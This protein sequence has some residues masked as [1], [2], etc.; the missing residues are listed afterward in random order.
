MSGFKNVISNDSEILI[1]YVLCK[2]L[3]RRK[4]FRMSSQ[5][6]ALHYCLSAVKP[7]EASVNG[8]EI[9][10]TVAES[11]CQDSGNPA[12]YTVSILLHNRS[13]SWFPTCYVDTPRGRKNTVSWSWPII[14]GLLQ[15]LEKCPL[16][17]VS[18][19]MPSHFT[20]CFAAAAFAL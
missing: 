10:G 16:V 12:L 18:P 17:I 9:P 11:L 3:K 1:M 2:C 19:N 5:H 14:N 20:Y 7:I 13:C 6:T 4:S 15:F 8:I